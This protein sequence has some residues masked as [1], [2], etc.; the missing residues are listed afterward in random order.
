MAAPASGPV[1][2]DWSTHSTQLVKELVDARAAIDKGNL[3]PALQERCCDIF[4]S[5]ST[6][7]ADFQ[8]VI[9]HPLLMD[10]AIYDCTFRLINLP[11]DE[12]KNIEKLW[13]DTCFRG[14][15]M[16]ADS[17]NINSPQTPPAT[18]TKVPNHD[19]NWLEES[20][21]PEAISILR[22]CADRFSVEGN[23][24]SFKHLI[25]VCLTIFAQINSHAS[26]TKYVFLPGFKNEY[27]NTLVDNAGLKDENLLGICFKT[28]A[29]LV[30][31]VPTLK[32]AQKQ[33]IDRVSD[34]YLAL[35]PKEEVLSN[36]GSGSS[37]AASSPN[38][39]VDGAA[40]ASPARATRK[41]AQRTLEQQALLNRLA[42]LQPTEAEEKSSPKP[43]P[44]VPASRT[45]IAIP[46]TATVAVI[47]IIALALIVSRRRQKIDS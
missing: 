30:K 34:L 37:S 32:S 8:K 26:K 41:P 18:P 19:V 21:A 11:E 25:Q 33:L 39:A 20:N 4:I 6:F 2:C 38:K 22:L 15:G 12:G 47:A 16:I 36:L 23:S 14:C 9:N 1:Q 45:G 29:Q 43:E 7:L 44:T 35:N 13:T 31:Q 10:A 24:N 28:W 3:E 5:L 40:N 27:I 42:G 17:R 46:L